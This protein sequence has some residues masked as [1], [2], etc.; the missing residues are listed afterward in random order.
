MK[1]KLLVIGCTS[2]IA[3]DFVDHTRDDYD[4]VGTYATEGG[5]IEK[6]YRQL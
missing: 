2:K 6:R 4:L 1:T 3:R 5:G